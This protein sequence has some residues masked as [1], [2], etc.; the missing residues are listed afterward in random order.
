VNDVQLGGTLILPVVAD[1]GQ[2]LPLG[3]ALAAGGV[4]TIEVTL[5]T[6]AALAA[7]ETLAKET[8]L[9]VGAGTVLSAQQADEAVDAGAR[10]RA[11]AAVALT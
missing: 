8:D 9:L 4:R 10:W 1:A 5:R 11:A 7:I 3:A 2:V 6:P